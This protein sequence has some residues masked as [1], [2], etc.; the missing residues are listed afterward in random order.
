MIGKYLNSGFCIK[1]AAE[2]RIHV[3]HLEVTHRGVNSQP[4]LC[5]LLA[6]LGARDALKL[7]AGIIAVTAE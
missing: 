2:G 1:V 7:K 5:R 4:E 6:N 3:S